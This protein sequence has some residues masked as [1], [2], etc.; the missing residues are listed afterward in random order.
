MG[1]LDSQRFL[2]VS[3]DYSQPYLIHEAWP[4]RST[5]EAGLPIT[6]KKKTFDGP[7]AFAKKQTE[8]NTPH[9][10]CFML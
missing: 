8:I 1:F 5:R 4:E 6:A 3:I 10:L 2:V 9:F 7:W